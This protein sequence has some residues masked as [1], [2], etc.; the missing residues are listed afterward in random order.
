MW[1]C[2][3]SDSDI[4]ISHLANEMLAREIGNIEVFL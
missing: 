4:L 1:Y 3:A 2:E